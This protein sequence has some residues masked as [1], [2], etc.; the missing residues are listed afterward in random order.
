MVFSD[1]DLDA[2]LQAHDNDACRRADC[3]LRRH[4]L[5][6]REQLREEDPRS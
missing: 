5:E 4:L 6:V 1:R 2:L 3:A